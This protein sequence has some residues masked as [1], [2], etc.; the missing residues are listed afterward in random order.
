MDPRAKRLIER[1][2]ALASDRG[3]W[4]SHWREIAELMSP[5]RDDFA[6]IR[7]PG[8]K[9]MSKI[10]DGTP[11]LA[12]ENLSS[13]LWGMLTNSSNKW[14]E[15]RTADEDLNESQG[16]REWLEAATTRM[17]VAFAAGGQRFYTRVVDLYS[18]L[19]HFGTGVFYVDEDMAGRGLHFSCRYLGE[20]YI[21]ENARERV[22]TVFRKHRMTAR[23]ALQKFGER[24]GPKLRA[25]AERSPEQMVDL[26]HVVLPA[27]EHDG[28]LP[29]TPPG[30]PAWGYASVYLSLED[31]NVLEERGYHEFPYQV[32]RWSQR[33]RS[34]YGDSPAMLALPDAK[35][36]NQ[37]SR[38]TIVGAQKAVDP[39]LL[40]PD[41]GSL[42]GVRISTRSGGLIYGGMDPQGRRL[43]DTL[44]PKGAL[45]LGLEMEEQ[46]RQAVREAFYASL[47]ML[48]SQPGRTATEVLALQEEKM[49][50]MGPHLGRVQSEFLDP[51]IERV[52][53]LLM[54]AGQIPPPPDELDGQRVEVEYVSPMARAQKASEAHAVA[55]TLE[56]AGPMAQLHPEV[57]DNFDL[58]AMVRLAGNAYGLPATMLRDPRAVEQMRQQR[59]QM[60]VAATV[61]QMAPGVA[62]AAKSGAEAQKIAQGAA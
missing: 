35:M 48:V 30:W 1:Q 55:R 56:I 24:L 62:Q 54:R 57:F 52:F 46:R 20:C 47:L 2:G 8:E 6:V 14:F 16:V 44:E 60:Q 4:E 13:G 11:G 58:D 50:L 39:P 12:S 15:L 37:M 36:L 21:A 53:G 43:F 40:A 3:T 19:V 23:Q 17:M 32:P 38:T 61:A 41:E 51:L 34:V 25:V 42:R 59:Q 7:T 5:M 29:K 22:D 31:C 45:G 33:S 18:D 27:E 28:A 10:F 49:R 26:L 9:R